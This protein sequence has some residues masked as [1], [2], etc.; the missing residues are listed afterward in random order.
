MASHSD[1]LSVKGDW[2]LMSWFSPT[3]LGALVN[4]TVLTLLLK[5]SAEKKTFQSR[6]LANSARF[7]R[8]FS[9]ETPPFLAP[10][11]ITDFGIALAKHCKSLSALLF[12]K[13]TDQTPFMTEH[14]LT[15]GVNGL[16]SFI[17]LWCNAAIGRKLRFQHT[18]PFMTKQMSQFGG[19]YLQSAQEVTESFDTKQQPQP[20]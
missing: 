20:N 14:A 15:C 4:V 7:L 18:L 11:G 16:V 6:R 3:F 19:G 8:F 5:S 13:S 10:D 9:L 17:C 12:Y 2:K 1:R